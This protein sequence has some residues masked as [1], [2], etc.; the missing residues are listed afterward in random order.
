MLTKQQQLEHPDNSLNTAGH[1]VLKHC[2]SCDMDNAIFAD[3]F[4]YC[5]NCEWSDPERNKCDR[6]GIH[7]DIPVKQRSTIIKDIDN[8]YY[9]CGKCAHN[10]KDVYKAIK[11]HPDQYDQ[12]VDQY[13]KRIYLPKCPDCGDCVRRWCE[14]GK[15][16]IEGAALG[17]FNPIHIG[18]E[19]YC[20]EL[21]AKKTI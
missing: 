1:I 5:A 6:C 4:G 11:D 12:A 20:Q 13:M 16:C 8:Y 19:N 14:D 7:N 3:S 21:N 18:E 15:F 9:L 10:F 17:C 2:I